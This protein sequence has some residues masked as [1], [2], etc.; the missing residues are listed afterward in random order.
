MLLARER[1][2]MNKTASQGRRHR[3]MEHVNTGKNIIYSRKQRV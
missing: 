1:I 3:D 2:K